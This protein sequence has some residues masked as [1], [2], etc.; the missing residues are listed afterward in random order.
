MMLYTASQS[1]IAGDYADNQQTAGFYIQSMIGI[2]L[3][4]RKPIA[5]QRIL[6]V[7]LIVLFSQ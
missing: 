1:G 6:L 7:F 2:R 4:V 5:P 3:E